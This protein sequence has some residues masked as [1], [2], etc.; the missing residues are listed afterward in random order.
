MAVKFVNAPVTEGNVLGY[1]ASD[2]IGFYGTTA[3]AAQ[4]SGLVLV[5]S[6]VAVTGAT[7]AWGFVSSAQANDAISMLRFVYSAM[8]SLNLAR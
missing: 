3:P 1:T 5:T 8:V 6:T 7:A 2:K 4:L